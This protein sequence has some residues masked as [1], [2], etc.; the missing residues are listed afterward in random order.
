MHQCVKCSTIF[1][2]GASEILRGCS[3][4]GGKFFFFVRKEALNKTLDLT[5]NLS[6]EDKE[7]IEKDVYDIIGVEEDKPVILDLA[8]V[9]ILGPGK[10][11]LDLVRLFKGDPMI[12][13]LEEGKYIID[14]AETFKNIKNNIKEK[15]K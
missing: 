5:K 13:R 7:K 14:L 1:G 4:C 8:S 2:D 9:N 10:F 12:Y 11:E 3:K 6:V 15:L